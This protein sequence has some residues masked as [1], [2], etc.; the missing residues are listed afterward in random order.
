M[1][2]V[3]PGNGVLGKADDKRGHVNLRANIEELSQHAFQQGP[4]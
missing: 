3:I 4:S 1:R 2:A